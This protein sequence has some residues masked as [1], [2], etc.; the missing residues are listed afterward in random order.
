MNFDE[1]Q[2][3]YSEIKRLSRQ[4][5]E[6]WSPQNVIEV[7]HALMHNRIEYIHNGGKIIAYAETWRIPLFEAEKLARGELINVLDYSLNWGPVLWIAQ[8]TFD[9][10]ARGIKEFLYELRDK[11]FM[12]NG[13]AKYIG[14]YRL[15]RKKGYIK[16][17]KKKEVV[18]G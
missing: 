8:V 1:I 12:N 5:E 6:C 7:A 11:V 2:I 18:Y 10:N 3:I 17:F 15:K 9:Y 4:H 14:W 16:P 13:T